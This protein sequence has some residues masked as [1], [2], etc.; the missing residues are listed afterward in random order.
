MRS[1]AR[2][3]LPVLVG[4]KTALISDWTEAL[5]STVNVREQER[6]ES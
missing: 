6:N 5:R 2:W 3:V 4:P 1:T